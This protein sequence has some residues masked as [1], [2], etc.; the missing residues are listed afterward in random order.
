MALHLAGLAPTWNEGSARVSGYEIIPLAILGRPRID[1]TLRTSGLF[2][3]V[4]FAGLSQIFE[5]GA[6]AL[7]TREEDPPSDNPYISPAPARVWPETGPLRD[8]D[9]GRFGGLLRRGP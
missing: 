9:D 2:R 1:V 4:F 8:G 7:S 6:E 3:D 5:S